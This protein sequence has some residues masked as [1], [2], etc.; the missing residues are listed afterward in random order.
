MPVPIDRIRQLNNH[1]ARAHGNYVL[2]WMIANRRTHWNFSLQRAVE[3]AEELKKPLLIFEGL[4]CDYQWASQRIHRFVLEG[5]ADNRARLK[6][7]PA[8]YHAWVEAKPGAGRG[9]LAA[10][11]R[12]ACA[13][14]S[15]DFPCFFLPRMLEAAAK[16]TKVAFEAVDSNGIF[17]L[18]ATDR[19]FTL[20]HSFRR[21]LQ[22]TIVPHLLVPPKSDP[23]ENVRLPKF[24]PSLL[25]DS[26]A[27]RWPQI[28]TPHSRRWDKTLA[29][30]PID[31]SVSRANFSGGPE[32]GRETMARF[33]KSRFSRYAEERNE[34][35]NEAA[36]GLSPYLHFGHISAHEVVA[37]ILEREKWTV[38]CLPEKPNGSRNG[39][40]GMSEPA[41]SFLDEIITWRELGYNMSWQRD[42]Y[43]KYESL[44]DWAQLTLKKHAKDPRPFLYEPEEFET[45]ATHDE[46]WNAAQRQ[47][48]REGRMHNYLRML[49]GKKILEWSP[50]PQEAADT[51]IHLNN[52]YAVDGRNPNSYSGIF[53]VLGRYDRAWGPE[54]PIFGRS[55]L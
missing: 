53:W 42:D 1:T 46:I 7:T 11:T 26:I 44:P 54:R 43:D 24:K 10:L 22:K 37:E 4:R 13:V 40:W 32:A 27:Q 17:P 20:A 28:P 19:V 52:K 9:L 30:L 6:S 50:T 51:M 31:Q 14:V 16:K 3:L 41:E 36:S 55:G 39:W 48:V 34:T 35:E 23:F 25:P 49:W 45:A 2:Y 12:N 29:G 18:R 38:N 15:D 5:M 33:F 21:H 47:L 8:G